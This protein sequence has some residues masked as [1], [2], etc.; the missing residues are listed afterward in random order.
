[1][2]RSVLILAREMFV[3]SKRMT[4]GSR[5]PYAETRNEQAIKTNIQQK[6]DFPKWG[7]TSTDWMHKRQLLIQ[8]ENGWNIARDMRMA[9]EDRLRARLDE[10]KQIANLTTG[11]RPL[12]IG[13]AGR[14]RAAQRAG[15]QVFSQ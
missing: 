14:S 7:P 1:M 5:A 10:E 15:E 9:Q 2:E 6:E 3:L 11:R 12:L 13:E 8:K 4:F